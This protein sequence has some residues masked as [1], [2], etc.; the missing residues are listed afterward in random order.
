MQDYSNLY[1]KPFRK[2]KFTEKEQLCFIRRILWKNVS[3][4]TKVACLMVF[5]SYVRR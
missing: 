1:P 3:P 4:I 5:L 2:K